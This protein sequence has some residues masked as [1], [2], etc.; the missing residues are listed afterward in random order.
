MHQQ[1]NVSFLIPNKNLFLLDIDFIWKGEGLAS[2]FHYQV[3]GSVQRR[4]P[5]SK[6]VRI[7][8]RLI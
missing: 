6:P 2:K 7:F 8:E 4:E 5:K 1:H 3:Y